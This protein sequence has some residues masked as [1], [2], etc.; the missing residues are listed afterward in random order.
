MHI[1]DLFFHTEI[2]QTVGSDVSD[3]WLLEQESVGSSKRTRSSTYNTQSAPRC[4]VTSSVC[5]S[6]QEQPAKGSCFQI[7]SSPTESRTQLESDIESIRLLLDEELGLDIGLL[8]TDAAHTVMHR[9]DRL[10]SI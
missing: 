7:Q 10:N 5:R 2:S 6:G 3:A 8:Y 4:L 1:T 9:L